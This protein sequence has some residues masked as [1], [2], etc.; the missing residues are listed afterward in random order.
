MFG[1]L[2]S[3]DNKTNSGTIVLFLSKHWRCCDDALSKFQIYAW[4][5]ANGID[6]N[7]TPPLYKVAALG[8][9]NTVNG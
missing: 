2:L 9:L 7:T 1:V 5:G 4:L 3:Y 6:G 8:W